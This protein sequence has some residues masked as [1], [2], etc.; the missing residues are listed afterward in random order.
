MVGPLLDAQDPPGIGAGVGG[1]G[2]GAGAA[3][4]WNVCV[5]AHALNVSPSPA[6]TRQKY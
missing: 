4:V 2:V 5:A 1:V 6:R 3:P